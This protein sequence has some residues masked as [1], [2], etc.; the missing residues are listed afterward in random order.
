MVPTVGKIV[1]I[2]DGELLESTGRY[3]GLSEGNLVGA[4]V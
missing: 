4:V 2:F 3:E 1:A